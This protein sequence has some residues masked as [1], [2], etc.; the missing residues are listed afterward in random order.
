VDKTLFVTQDVAAKLLTKR[1]QRSFRILRSVDRQF[2]T[3]VSV[4]EPPSRVKLTFQDE[5]D[6]VSRNVDKKPPF[7]AA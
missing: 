3:G 1:L 4:S 7:Y 2:I 6:K 5:A